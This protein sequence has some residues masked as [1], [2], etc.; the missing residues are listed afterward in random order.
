M[1][2]LERDA[3]SSL[4]CSHLARLEY[5][6][7]RSFEWAP[8]K[9]AG[10]QPSFWH[11]LFC[12]S[13]PFFCQ[14]AFLPD[15]ESQKQED[16]GWI[17]SEKDKRKDGRPMN[18]GRTSHAHTLLPTTKAW[19]LD[20]FC[21]QEKITIASLKKG[22]SPEK[23]ACLLAVSTHLRRTLSTCSFHDPTPDTKSEARIR[24]GE[25]RAS[26][27]LFPSSPSW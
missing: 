10:F 8:W 16:M 18:F 3:I 2:G 27:T 4:L 9:V 15:K 23:E 13:P 6:R 17:S 11:L 25:S 1:D 26:R 20:T 14:E 19:P 22:D 24:R 5:L 21:H 7:Y 12:P